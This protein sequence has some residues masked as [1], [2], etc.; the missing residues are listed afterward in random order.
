MFVDY[1]WLQMLTGPFDKFK[2]TLTVNNKQYSYFDLSE[3]GPEYGNIIYKI[4]N[5]DYIC[6]LYYSIIFII[7]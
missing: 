2:K 5:F 1:L 4:I 7:I 3:F 6:I